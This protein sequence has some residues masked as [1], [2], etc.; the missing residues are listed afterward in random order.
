MKPCSMS[1][2]KPA[3]HLEATA[4]GSDLTFFDTDAA[5]RLFNLER[6][7]PPSGVGF[8]YDGRGYLTFAD[9]KVL[10]FADGFE[11]GTTCFWTATSGLAPPAPVCPPPKPTVKPTYSSEGLL[12]ALTRNVSPQSNAPRGRLMPLSSETSQHLQRVLSHRPVW[13]LKGALPG[14]RSQPSTAAGAQG[15]TESM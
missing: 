4:A 7:L 5:G 2:R 10:P 9:P 3:G 13:P 8:R 11:S 14:C 15:G 12:H 1:A 6:T